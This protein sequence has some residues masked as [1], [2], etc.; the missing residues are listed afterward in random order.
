M[1]YSLSSKLTDSWE[2][3][4][5][6]C[7]RKSKP[8]IHTDISS[9][10]SIQIEL[11]HPFNPNGFYF[12]SKVA[13]G[14]HEMWKCFAIT[15]GP[16]FSKY[17]FIFF[18]QINYRL[19]SIL[20]VSVR[21]NKIHVFDEACFPLCSFCYIPLSHFHGNHCYGRKLLRHNYATYQSKLSMKKGTQ[22]DKD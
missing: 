2:S 3:K 8:C 4:Q 7:V 15:F 17:T 22:A 20:S 13:E 14:I 19:N 9:I 10:S 5:V 12:K 16:F 6:L 18:S 21:I 1:W 11:N